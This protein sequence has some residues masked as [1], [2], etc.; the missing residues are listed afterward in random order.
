[1]IIRKPDAAP[2]LSRTNETTANRPGDSADVRMIHELM[3][4]FRLH[5]LV[6]TTEAEALAGVHFRDSAFAARR[7]GLNSTGSLGVSQGPPTADPGCSGGAGNMIGY[8]AGI[9]YIGLSVGVLGQFGVATY[10][11]KYINADGRAKYGRAI[12]WL[13]KE[14]GGWRII[15]TFYMDLDDVVY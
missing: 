11:P 15:G 5:T 8:R 12:C 13:A 4:G 3:E 14:D 1:M 6:T 7:V 10:E 2:P 9:E